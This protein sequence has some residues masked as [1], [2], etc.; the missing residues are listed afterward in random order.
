MTDTQDLLATFD[1]K[2][3]EYLKQFRFD[4]QT[5]T[6]LRDELE[7][8]LFTKAR[9]FI[10]AKLEPNQPEPITKQV[11]NLKLPSNFLEI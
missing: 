11:A 1:P 8:G 9:N 10:D 6:K 2:S 4:A 3:L 7:K 5:F